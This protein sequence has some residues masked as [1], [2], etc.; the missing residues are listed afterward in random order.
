MKPGAQ[1][2]KQR[3]EREKTNDKGLKSK[4]TFQM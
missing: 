2:R 4:M 1:W 3:G